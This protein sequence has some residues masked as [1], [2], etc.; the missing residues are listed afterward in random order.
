MTAA[1]LQLDRIDALRDAANKFHKILSALSAQ[2]L[3]DRDRPLT[4]P[5]RRSLTEKLLDG[6]SLEQIAADGFETC[7]RALAA[8]GAP[9]VTIFE[10]DPTEEPS[11]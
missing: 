2:R 7:V 1:T 8:A 3:L 9:D 5:L 10:C 11:G 6:P 4:E